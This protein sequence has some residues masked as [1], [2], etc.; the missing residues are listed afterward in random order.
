MKKKFKKIIFDIPKSLELKK[1]GKLKSITQITSKLEKRLGKNPVDFNA[2]KKLAIL[3]SNRRKSINR[4]DFDFESAY[5]I[6]KK[7]FSIFLADEAD[8]D[9]IDSIIESF[10]NY[11]IYNSYSEIKKIFLSFYER[12][13]IPKEVLE[14]YVNLKK[15]EL[16]YSE[17]VK[18]GFINIPYAAI[19]TDEKNQ[20]RL[21]SPIRGKYIFR[22]HC[23][24]RQNYRQFQ[25]ISLLQ[26]CEA[27]FSTYYNSFIEV[28]SYAEFRKKYSG[29]KYICIDG[30]NI[31][32]S[33]KFLDLNRKKQFDIILN[34]HSDK[35]LKAVQ[36]NQTKEKKCFEDSGCFQLESSLSDIECAVID[37][38][39]ISGAP[40]LI[41]D[42]LLDACCSA[43]VI[44]PINVKDKFKSGKPDAF[45][46]V[47]VSLSD[48]KLKEFLEFIDSFKVE[49]P[50]IPVIIGGASSIQYRELFSLLDY[51]EIYIY[52]G[53]ADEQLPRLINILK[54]KHIFNS[55][56]S[57]KLN[58]LTG[59]LYRDRNCVG[60]IKPDIPYN[61]KR[62]R[63]YLPA[64][65][66]NGRDFDWNPNRG[67]PNRC[68]YCNN[69][70]GRWRSA[71]QAE[72]RGHIL[73]IVGKTAGFDSVLMKII[74]DEINEELPLNFGV[75][76]FEKKTYPADKLIRI[77]DCY[78]A[79]FELD[80]KSFLP[81]LDYI[82][83]DRRSLSVVLFY[84]ALLIINAL[85]VLNTQRISEL[86]KFT[87][88][89]INIFTASD[90]FMV[91][92]AAVIEFF[93]WIRELNL[94]KYFSIRSQSSIN[95][96]W[97]NKNGVPKYELLENIYAAGIESLGIGYDSSSNRIGFDVLKTNTYSMMVKTL[98]SMI[99]SGFKIEDIRI[100]HFYSSP[101]SSF[102]DSLE[103]LLLSAANICN[104][105]GNMI[106]RVLYTYRSEFGIIGKMWF[107]E[108]KDSWLDKF[109][110]YMNGSVDYAYLPAEIS[111]LPMLDAKAE[112]F[113]KLLF[114]F[115]ENTQ[116]FE[117]AFNEKFIFSTVFKNEIIDII[118]KWDSENQQDQEIRILGRLISRIISS[119]PE[120]H[121]RDIFKFIK[122]SCIKYGI[123]SFVNLAKKIGIDR[124]VNEYRKID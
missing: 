93:K 74:S 81:Y 78:C 31:K 27:E 100:H 14:F 5:L 97:D 34:L 9:R 86:E 77:L 66:R 18:T 111:F 123:Y 68:A 110:N 124:I 51:D 36:T 35:N 121:I 116:E 107:A 98:D 16:T 11:L 71:D 108:R 45:K 57:E 28:Y 23:E 88:Q 95:I 17:T 60:I 53:D 26:F 82:L 89:R 41:R 46:I 47:C 65:D 20:Y 8:I 40:F 115:N 103:G 105:R 99:A 87:D 69:V 32:I 49:N 83:K 62:V 85:C 4:F 56:I 55:D 76:D 79:R 29:N 3:Y 75:D 101:I 96:L 106:A 109:A 2:L 104:D 90:N 39:S 80:K 118:S 54:E 25:L 52:I 22:F 119:N 21:E 92:S 1:I 61:V 114:N 73:S 59:I 50:D 48:R 67:C 70:Q 37:F 94:K 63:L 91:E 43:A 15:R 13:E 7:C 12:Y 19:I 113:V 120:T 33:D 112:A 58:G 38:H 102:E 84:K 122:N 44:Q 30:Q 117:N 10:R 42:I 64:F 72:M 24:K 6:L